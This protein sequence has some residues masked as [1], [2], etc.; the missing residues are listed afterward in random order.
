VLPSLKLLLLNPLIPSVANKTESRVAAEFSTRSTISFLLAVLSSHFIRAKPSIGHKKTVEEL[1]KFPVYNIVER[2]NCEVLDIDINDKDAPPLLPVLDQLVTSSDE[3]TVFMS[4]KVIH[5]K[6]DWFISKRPSAQ[7]QPFLD[8]NSRDV[9][10]TELSGDKHHRGVR[11]TLN[12]TFTAGG[13]C[14]PAFA[15][16]YGMTAKEMPHDEIVIKEV[17]GSTS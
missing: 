4:D 14:A 9:F 11:V 10:C 1:R 6:D 16:V 2:L 5:S 8:S 7:Q 13:R 17:P 3:M 12:N 15:C